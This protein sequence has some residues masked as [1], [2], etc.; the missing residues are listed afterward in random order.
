MKAS[1]ALRK[2]KALIEDPQHWC[3]GVYAKGK[4]GREVDVKSRY[5]DQWCAA[6]AMDKVNPR[7][8]F[9]GD[10]YLNRAARDL[11]DQHFITVNDRLA[12]MDVMRMYDR[13]IELALEDENREQGE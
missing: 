4:S 13:A 8:T 9:S 10:L 11:Y 3:Q 6:G 12:H 1:E 7:N 2:A 5:A